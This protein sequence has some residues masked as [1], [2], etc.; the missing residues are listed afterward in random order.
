[1]TG[2]ALCLALCLAISGCGTA[3]GSTERVDVMRRILPSAVQLRAERE[4][5]ARRAASGVV[6]ASD[7]R[8]SR[9]FVLTTRPL[10]DTA[11][12]QDVVV[13]TTAGRGRANDVVKAER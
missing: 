9:S 12:K 13:S 1:M 4:G 7:A 2:R 3:G 5:G 11:A 8:A 10:L 6:L